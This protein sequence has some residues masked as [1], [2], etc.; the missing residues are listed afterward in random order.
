MNRH[1]DGNRNQN[2]LAD[3][4]EHAQ[5]VDFNPLVRKEPNQS[6]GY[7]GRQKRRAAG[8]GNRQR[9]IAARQEGHDV[10]RGSARAAAY[11][12]H[13]HGDFGRQLQHDA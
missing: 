12:D 5:R 10:G 8:D 13:A 6:R 11:E 2:D 3:R 7:D 9:R 4:P 1:A